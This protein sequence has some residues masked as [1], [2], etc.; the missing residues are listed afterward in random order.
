VDHKNLIENELN[1]TDLNIFKFIK[2]LNLNYQDF[3]LKNHY[4]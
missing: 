1:I 2:N 3:N 4:D